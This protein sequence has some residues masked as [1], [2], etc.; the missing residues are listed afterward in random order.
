MAGDDFRRRVDRDSAL[1]GLVL[2]YTHS[3][4]AQVSLSL[5]CNSLH[6]VVCRLGR[7]LLLV[8]NRAGA[9]QFPLT[10]EF[11]AAMLGVRR[12]TVTEAAGALQRDGLIRYG[13]GMVTVLD[14]PGLES[15]AC[16][17]YRAIRAHLDVPPGRGPGSAAQ[18]SVP[19]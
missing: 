6:P 9:D 14:R 17:C 19:P 5:A 2:R 4:L 11:L 18:K 7:W 16:G 15:A 3:F 13:R 10:H 12:A 1:H 8:H